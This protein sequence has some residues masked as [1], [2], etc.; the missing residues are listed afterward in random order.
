MTEV[1]KINAIPFVFIVGRG[2]SGTS[3]LQTMLDCHPQ[4]VSANESTFILVLKKKYD[5]VKVWTQQLVEEFLDDLYADPKFVH[6]WNIP[7]KTLSDYIARFPFEQLSYIFLCRLVYFNFPSLHK[8]HDVKWLVDKNPIYSLF[9]EDILQIFPKA[10][11]IHIIRDYRDNIVSRRKSFGQND[12]AL[13]ANDW[14]GFHKAIDAFETKYPHLVHNLKY[15]DLARDPEKNLRSICDFLGVPFEA[16]M[17]RFH[18][19]TNKSF[20]E[21]KD[22]ISKDVNDQIHSN[23]LNP[24]NTTAVA[25]WKKELKASEIEMID[26]IAGKYARSKGYEPGPIIKNNSYRWT[27][28]KKRIQ[29]WLTFGVTRMYYIN[30]PYVLR[31]WLTATSAMLHRVFGYTNRYNRLKYKLQG[32]EEQN[33]NG[34]A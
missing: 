12:L 26:S 9:M 18:E 3:L 29:F 5:R 21:N 14:M 10:K 23:L 28:L 24:V 11:F 17:L 34:K 20:K 33:E 22:K 30:M 8:K 4:L 2:R 19:A 25:K 15:E 27:L 6:F 13:L 31:H 1:D 7:R 16:A 32:A